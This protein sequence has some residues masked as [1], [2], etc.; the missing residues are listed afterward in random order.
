M[1]TRASEASKTGYADKRRRSQRARG[2][3]SQKPWARLQAAIPTAALTRRQHSNSSRIQ[4]S[5][6]V[7]GGRA[8][9]LKELLRQLEVLARV[10]G[11]AHTG[12]DDALED[13]LLWRGRLQ[14]LYEVVGLQA[15]E[16]GAC[17]E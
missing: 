2:K 1:T 17:N 7:P 6:H 15:G 10:R 14:V 4:L 8:D 5:Q 13:V 12:V 11:L 16:T 3:A 9:E